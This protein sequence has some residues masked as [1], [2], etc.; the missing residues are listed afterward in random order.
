MEWAWLFLVF[1]NELADWKAIALLTASRPTHLAEIVRREPTHLGF[2]DASGLGAGGVW[3]DPAGTFHNM[4]WRHPL[5]ADVTSVL[6]SST[7]SHGA[8]DNSELELAT[9]VLQ[10]ATLLDAVPKARMAAPHSDSDNMPTVFQ[11]THKASMMNPV[12]ADLLCIH[13]L[14]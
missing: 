11:S 4:V 12:V 2:C 6:V 13:A 8:M 5:P 7:N 10:E 9:L 3:I 1:H 14:H